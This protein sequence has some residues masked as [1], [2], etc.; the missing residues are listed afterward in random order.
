MPLLKAGDLERK[1][2]QFKWSV[3]GMLE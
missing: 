1:L 2:G 3:G